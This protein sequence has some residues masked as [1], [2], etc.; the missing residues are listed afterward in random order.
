MIKIAPSILAGDFV[1]MADSVRIAEEAGA[2]YLHCD[3][4]DGVF[5]P[6]I[7]FGFPMIEAIRE[8]TT[9][10]LDVHLMIDQPSRY[11]ERFARAGADIITFHVEAETHIQRTLQAIRDCGKKAGIVFNPATPLGC[12]PYVLE[13]VDMILL[14]SVNPGY[15]GQKFLPSALQKIREL[16]AMTDASG[17]DVE[18]EVDG[19]VSPATAASV[20]SAGANVLVAGSAVFHAADPAAVVEAI[21]RGG[22]S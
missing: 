9:L 20:I 3:V 4:M 2:D 13:D 11:V 6:N 10:P 7:S 19:G 14:M 22:E 21:R 8:I 15:G 16:R 5:V 17:R 12:V 1:R 18:I